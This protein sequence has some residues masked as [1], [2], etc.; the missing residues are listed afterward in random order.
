MFNVV[1]LICL[2]P[3]R[4]TIETYSTEVK[5]VAVELLGSLSLIMGMEKR[6]SP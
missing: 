4:E 2:Y 5:T 1:F 3:H 6:L